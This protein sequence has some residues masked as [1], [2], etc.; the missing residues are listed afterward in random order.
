MLLQNIFLIFKNAVNKNFINAILVS[1]E[2]YYILHDL[3]ISIFS[4][5]KPEKVSKITAPECLIAYPVCLSG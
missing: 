5:A 3:L 4:D 2:Q 1:D